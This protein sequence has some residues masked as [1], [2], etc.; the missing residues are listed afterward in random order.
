MESLGEEAP[1]EEGKVGSREE[2]REESDGEYEIQ[3]QARSCKEEVCKVSITCEAAPAMPRC[4]SGRQAKE[5]SISH[6]TFR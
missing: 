4:V 3:P 6:L 1:A 5:G 2:I